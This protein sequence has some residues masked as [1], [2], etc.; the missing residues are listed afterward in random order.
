MKNERNDV[1]EFFIGLAMLCIGGYLFLQNVDVF[2]GNLFSFYIG[3]HNMSGMLFMPLIASIIFLF[4]KYN[5]VSKICCVLSILIIVFN[6]IMNLRVY[7]KGTTLFV[8]ICIFILL[9]G[10]MGLVMRVIFANPGGKHGK[11]YKDPDDN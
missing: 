5:L 7:W 9:F 1:A 2:S 6:V 11:N 4:Y 8:T 10:G 3:D